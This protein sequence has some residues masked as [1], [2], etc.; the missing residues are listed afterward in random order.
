[1]RYIFFILTLWLFSCH[2]SESQVSNQSNMETKQEKGDF[3]VLGGGCFWCVEAVFQRMEGVLAVESGYS[4]G[5]TK[6]PTYTEICTGNTGH[7][8]VIKIFYDPAK[9]DLK[10][11]L[12]VFFL[13]HD[14][15]TLNKQGNDEGTQ[16]RSV[17]FYQNENE[18]K[19]SEEAK[20]AAAKYYT[21]PIVT[22]ISPLINY[23]K[24]EDYHQNYFNG[25]KRQPYCQYVV[26]PKVEKFEK[27]FKDKVKK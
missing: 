12:E 24:A 3:I 13:T 23:Y 22:E 15:T 19:I 2:N 25:N 4:G 17:V 18:K 10:A 21:S 8:E 11:I 27:L 20:L 1:M 7:A 26:L 14:P 9:A 16:Y 5:Q 6:N